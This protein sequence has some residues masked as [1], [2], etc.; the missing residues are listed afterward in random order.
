MENNKFINKALEVSGRI[1]ANIYLD[2]ISKGLMGTLPILMIG[3]LALLFGVFPFDP[4]LNFIQS[5]GIEKYFLAA[6]T[7]TTSCLSIYASFLIGHRLAGHF[8]CDQIPAGLISIFAFFITTPLTEESALSMQFMGAQGL[9]GAMIAALIATRLYCFFMT[10]EKLKIHMPEGVPPMIANT[11]SALIPGILVGFIFIFVSFGFSFTSWGSFSQMV[12]SVI[13]TPLNALGGSVWSLV[14][15]LLVQMFLWFFGIHGTNTLDMVAKQLFEPGVQINQALIQN[16]QLPTEL[17]SKTF[18][19]IFVFIGGCG[20]A[21]CLILA[22]FIAAK[23]SNNKK[24]AKVA[25]ISVFFN[26]NE[27]VIFGFPVIFNPIML[28]PFILIPLVLTIISS[29]AMSTGIVPYISQSVEWTVPII[30]S[31]YQATGSIA[32]SFLQIF[33]IIIG[34]MLYIPFVKYSEQIQSK[35]FEESILALE[36][37]MI[38]GEQNGSIPVFLSDH[39]HYHFPAKTLAMDLRNAMYLHQLQLYYQVQMTAEEQVYGVEALLRWNHPVCGFVAPSLLISL[40]Y[41]G[42]F[43]NE[44]GLYIIEKACQDAEQIDRLAMKMNLSINISPKQLEDADFV[45]N[46]LKII[47]KY[48][49]QYIEL[50]FEVT[51]R[52]LLNTTNIITKRILELRDSGIK[53]SIDDF[54]MGHSSIT[55]LQ[56]NIFDEVKLD[57]SLV[58]HLLENDRTREIIMSIT[59]IAKRL[60]FSVVAEFVETEEQINVLK[61]AGCKIYQGYY[62]AKAV[63]LD[64]FLQY[65]LITRNGII[66]S[67]INEKV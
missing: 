27:I 53:L 19:D 5:T 67:P 15:L 4:W 18:L 6:S 21:L 49:L 60:N 45:S 26:I 50:V 61:E 28:I 16:G 3:S 2:S 25:G 33:N 29:I 35:E 34:T 38:E 20:T 7:V 44:L 64:E 51:E 40:A 9:F 59:Q 57:G 31:G 41:Q 8:K 58:Q 23:K 1:A 24:L 39:Y 30:L 37:D 62:Y 63:P 36:N 13:V 54:G 65:C 10:K 43:L 14:V 48:H 52:A 12:Y 46:V 32:G 66:R 22:I 17:F 11:F 47:N 42:G 55:Y 56:E